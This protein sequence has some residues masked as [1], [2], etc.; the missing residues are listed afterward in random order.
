MADSQT[1]DKIEEFIRKLVNVTNIFDMY[2][3]S[4]KIS[5]EAVSDLYSVLKEALSKKEEIT[6][7][8]IGNEIAYEKEPYYELSESVKGFI[9]HLKDIKLEKMSFSKGLKEGELK[10]FIA[11]LNT[12]PKT[13]KSKSIE[14]VFEASSIKCIAVGKI[15][16][17][18]EE[19]KTTEEEVDIKALVEGTYT[20]ATDFLAK[21]IENAKQNKPIDVGQAR[22]LVN[23]IASNLIRNKDLLSILTSTRSHDESTFV[24]Q[25]NVAIFTMLQA[26]SLGIPEEFINDIGVSALLH[27]VGK[28]AISGDIIRKAGQLDSS[29]REKIS[30]HPI[31]G[32]KILLEM[33][34]VS[35]VAAITAFEHHVKYD[36]SGYPEKIF[37]KKINLVAM[38]TTIADFYDAVRSERAYHEGFAPEKAYEEMMELSGV[39]FHPD[40]LEHFFTIVGVYPPGTLVELDTGETGLVIKESAMDIS[41]PQVELLYDSKGGKY[42]D[43]QVANLLEKNGKDNY[44]WNIIRSIAPSDKLKAPE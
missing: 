6:I 34:G 10:E 5:T 7:G 20:D 38:I 43:V 14:D 21:T 35:P 16:F 25:V 29:E 2:G 22:N 17:R 36:L 31:D 32:A 26:E 12:K 13:L 39:F 1:R 9:E 11:I 8:V 27:D 23:G 41:R 19:G 18:K 28:M 24:H 30:R 40:L 37:G 3:E 44:K 15:G 33:P 4:H 42:K